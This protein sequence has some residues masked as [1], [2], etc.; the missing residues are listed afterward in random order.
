[1]RIGQSRCRKSKLESGSISAFG[2][3][4][5]GSMRHAHTTL[6][7][8]GLSQLLETN[9]QKL[10]EFCFYS[11]HLSQSCSLSGSILACY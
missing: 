3:G 9:I 11:G 10:T 8:S 1:L 4:H 6:G 5:Q 2:S 7:S